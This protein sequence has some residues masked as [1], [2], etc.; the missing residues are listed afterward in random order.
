MENR[1]QTN[2]AVPR[3]CDRRI[4]RQRVR[5][6]R[7]VGHAATLVVATLIG[8]AGATVAG[9]RGTTPSTWDVYDVPQLGH[10]PVRGSGCGGDGSIGDVIP[11]GYWRGYMTSL[12]SVR[13]TLHFDLVCVYFAPHD[14]TI[15]VVP[16]GYMTNNSARTRTVRIASTFFVRGTRFL[17]DGSV[18]FDGE[19][20]PFEGTDAWLYIESG[21]A[22]WL[23]GSPLAEGPVAAPPAPP[24]GLGRL[25]AQ[26]DVVGHVGPIEMPDGTQVAVLTRS[27]AVAMTATV[28]LA[29]RRSDGWIIEQQIP[30]DG[31]FVPDA[32]QAIGDLTGDGRTEIRVPLISSTGG[33]DWDLLFRTQSESPSLH[34]IPFDVAALETIG[35]VPMSLHIDSVTDDRV[36][37]TIG[38]CTP[39]CADDI[40]APAVW[41]LDRSGDW[42]LRLLSAPQSGAPA[43]P[44]LAPGPIDISSPLLSGYQQNRITEMELGLPAQLASDA[45]ALSSLTGWQWSEDMVIALGASFCNGWEW[46]ASAD[47]TYDGLSENGRHSWAAAIAPVL[48]ID[49]TAA[50]IAIDASYEHGIVPAHQWICQ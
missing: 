39:S 16:D 47:G 11:D 37:T 3:T 31:G 46:A 34:E 40:R 4:H 50:R 12:D 15:E 35:I 28:E 32:P 18:P 27:D 5:A 22:Q 7:R 6:V 49:A 30:I 1:Y 17:P 48:G 29:V 38:T 23:I 33:K 44:L 9:A 10:E 21:Q 14:S 20:V 8:I 42:T 2:M 19:D 25:T 45:H 41:Y 43:A 36:I 13:G 26:P 24:D